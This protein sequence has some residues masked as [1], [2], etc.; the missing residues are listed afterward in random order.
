M[1]RIRRAFHVIQKEQNHAP[2]PILKI[3]HFDLGLLLADPQIPLPQELFRSMR[4]FNL[5][6]SF[7]EDELGQF[8][9]HLY[10]QEVMF[11]HP[12]DLPRDFF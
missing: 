7:R 6:A 1:L 11:N 10:F 4:A 8:T 2:V 5:P 9:A 3:T 12:I